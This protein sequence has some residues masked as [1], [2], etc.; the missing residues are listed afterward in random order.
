METRGIRIGLPSVFKDKDVEFPVYLIDSAPRRN[1]LC[2]S[3]NG[4]PVTTLQAVS[5][6]R[7]TASC[8]AD[9]PEDGFQLSATPSSRVVA[10]TASMDEARLMGVLRA[11]E[12]TVKSHVSHVLGKLQVDNRAQAIVLALKRGLISLEE[13]D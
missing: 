7:Y 2:R 12:E 6:S 9:S 11:G 8:R 5:P 1:V 4:F 3:C 13:L 10:L